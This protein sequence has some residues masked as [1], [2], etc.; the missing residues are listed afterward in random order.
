MG[1]NTL[2]VVK[3]NKA[4][5][6]NTPEFREWRSVHIGKSTPSPSPSGV[7]AGIHSH[8]TGQ[9]AWP[10]ASKHSYQNQ[11]P[12]CYHIIMPKDLFLQM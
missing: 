9:E 7:D 12:E 10:R 11:V 5:K 6:E 2:K 1:G 4:L 3:Y 8:T